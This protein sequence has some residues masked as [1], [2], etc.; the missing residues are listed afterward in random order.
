MKVYTK[1]IF[2]KTSVFTIKKYL[3]ILFFRYFQ[4]GK[5]HKKFMRGSVL[6]TST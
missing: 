4:K 2:D 5:E 6:G 1:P 3:Y